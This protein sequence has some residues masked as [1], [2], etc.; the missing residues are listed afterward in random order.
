MATYDRGDLVRLTATFT[1]SSVATDPTSVV[2][3]VRSPTGTLTTLTYGVD[4]A[5]VKVSTGVYRYDYSASAVG[6]V[7]FRWA[8]TGVAQAASQDSFF[9][10]DDV[11]V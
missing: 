2:L 11:Q 6:N 9:V 8:S 7:T 3:Y 10:Y 4:G 5:V 1:V